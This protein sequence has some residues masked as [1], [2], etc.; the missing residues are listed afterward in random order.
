MNT[1]V[2]LDAVRESA[3]RSVRRTDM[4]F[5]IVLVF[6]ALVEAGGLAGLMLLADFKDRLHQVLLLQT[7]LVYGTLSLG[8]IAVGVLVRQG[9]LRILTALERS[10]LD[11]DGGPA[12]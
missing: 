5:R 8:L 7:L 2:N 11:G 10:A 6:A 9:T 12:R 1:N 3:L 4:F